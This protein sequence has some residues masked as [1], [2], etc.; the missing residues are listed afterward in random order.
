MLDELREIA[1]VTATPRFTRI[2]RWPKSMAQ[3]TVGHAARLREI[4]ERAAAEGVLK[5]SKG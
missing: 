1:G 4:Q 5:G 2:A 3:Y